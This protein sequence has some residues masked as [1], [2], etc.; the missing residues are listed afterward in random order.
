MNDMRLRNRLRLWRVEENCTLEDVSG[1]TGY[2]VSM[3][4][5]AERGERVFSPKAKVRIA[6]CLGVQVADLFEPEEL[7]EAQ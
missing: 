4:S 6:R 5:R 3:L 2:S 1:L 7:E